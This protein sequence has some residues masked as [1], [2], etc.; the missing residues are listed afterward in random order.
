[1]PIEGEDIGVRVIAGDQ[2]ERGNPRKSSRGI[3]D[4]VAI[5]VWN[6]FV[7]SFLAMTQFY[8]QLRHIDILV[9]PVI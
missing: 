8:R 6:C 2:S 3:R 5:S 4:A 7:T 9:S 1:M